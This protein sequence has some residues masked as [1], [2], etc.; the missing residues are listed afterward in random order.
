M[1]RD[2]SITLTWATDDHHFRLA[3]GELA[4]LQEERDSG[5]Y[6]V[7]D[8]L[9][10][11]RWHVQDIAAVIRLG[12]IGGGLEPVKALKLVRD[13]VESR[14]PLENLETAQRVLGA[15]IVG[16]PDEDDVGKKSEAA[17]QEE[18]VSPNSLT[19]SSGLPPSTTTEPS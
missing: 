7:L 19:G 9:V 17:N 3:W 11:G 4:K 16:A 15:A 14:P 10:S 5:P 8:R 12:L 18:Q 1:S 13:Y 6:V 2:A